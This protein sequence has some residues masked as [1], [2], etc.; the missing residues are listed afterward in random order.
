MSH[1]ELIIVPIILH[2]EKE[3]A[4]LSIPTVSSAILV[5]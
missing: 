1:E 3:I 4:I 5:C 2:P